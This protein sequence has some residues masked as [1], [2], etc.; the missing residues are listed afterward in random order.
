MELLEFNV[1]GLF[2]PAGNFY[3]DPVRA[4]DHAI[5]THGH[6]DHARPGHK[7]YLSS[8]KSVNI[9][10]Y[11][12]GKHIN[13]EGLPYGESKYINGIKI[14]LH[15]AGHITGS[16]QV[17]LEHQGCVWVISGDYKLQNDGLAE[18]FDIIPCDYFVTECT[19]GLPVYKWRA[20]EMVFNDIN[21]WWEA[22]SKMNRPSV[23]SA[24]SLGKAQ[25][26]IWNINS[27]IGPV[28]VHSA[29]GNLIKVY[30][31]LGL[32]F[33]NWEYL[34]PNT[35][36][37][38]INKSLILMPPSAINS[39]AINKIKNHSIG[40]ASGWMALRGNRR[41]RGA[42]RG[43]VLSD[44]CDWGGLNHVVKETGAS[45]IYAHHGYTAIFTR[46]LTENG[47]D[48]GSLQPG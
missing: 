25:R 13:I 35:S 32:K 22:N 38:K 24:Y 31:T 33:K 34:N 16:S 10:K 1:N 3:I 41:R 42:D 43:F 40:I 20:Q 2:C 46:W 11:R 21:A 26:I 23:L 6:S 36:R 12:L 45:T 19:F 30:E 37:E 4:V 18:P 7:Q 5:I 44:H 8:E 39:P 27:D 47:Y 28:L 14:S 29:I 48:A 17:R 15:P 9:L